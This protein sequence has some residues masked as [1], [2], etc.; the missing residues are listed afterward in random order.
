MILFVALQ[1]GKLK[2]F[3]KQNKSLGRELYV[4]P[5]LFLKAQFLYILARSVRLFVTDSSYRSFQ[6]IIIG[7]NLRDHSLISLKQ[8]RKLTN[9]VTITRKSVCSFLDYIYNMIKQSYY[10]IEMMRHKAKYL[11]DQVLR[12][13]YIRIKDPLLK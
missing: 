4:L 7:Q 9:S 12:Y 8:F 1:L 13:K 5:F 3:I 11:Y 6:Y 2:I 10:L